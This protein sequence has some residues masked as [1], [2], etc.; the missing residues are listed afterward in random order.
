MGLWGVFPA[1]SQYQE[2]FPCFSHCLPDAY[3][4]QHPFRF[5]TSSTLRISDAIP[6]TPQN[7]STSF[8]KFK[9]KS[10]TAITSIL[11]L[12]LAATAAPTLQARWCTPV[13]CCDDV[14]TVGEVCAAGLDNAVTYCC[15]EN[16]ET[17]SS[18]TNYSKI[19]I[20]AA[21]LLSRPHLWRFCVFMRMVLAL[22]NRLGLSEIGPRTI[23]LWAR[24]MRLQ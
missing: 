11:G 22:L 17:V 10:I 6:S 12:A 20:P 19:A 3:I 13:C 2:W 18:S 9:M 16:L 14:C 1:I 5:L 23:W 8:N 24:F 4:Y 7:P 15:N 21:N